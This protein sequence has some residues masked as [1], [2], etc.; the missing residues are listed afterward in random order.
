MESAYPDLQEDAKGQLT[1][2]HYLGQLEH[3]QRAFSVKQKRPNTVDE[4]VSASL[5][6]E[7]YLLP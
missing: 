7:S 5:E 1:L 4:A 6:I 3:Q 2:T